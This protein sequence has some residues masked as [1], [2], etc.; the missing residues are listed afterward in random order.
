MN[1]KSE[2]REPL[3]PKPEGSRR[4][5][6]I[7]CAIAVF[8]GFASIAKGCNKTFDAIKD[9]KGLQIERTVADTAKDTGNVKP[10]ITK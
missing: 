10:V 9:A 5:I 8:A 2:N 7:V 3:A 4:F 1:D 6:L